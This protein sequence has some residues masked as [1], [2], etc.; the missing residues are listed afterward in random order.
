MQSLHETQA[1]FRDAIV[2][3]E[4]QLPASLI[5]PAPIAGRLAIYR[6]HFREALV[7]H[8]VGRF[9]T[10]EWLIGSR[11]MAEF[12]EPFVRSSPPTAPCLAEYGAGFVDAL[13]VSGRAE[14]PAYLEDVAVLDWALGDV[15]VAIDHAPLDVAALASYPAE[16]L[17]DLTLRL[18]PGLRY[19]RSAWPVDA[20]VGIRL[21][22][23]APDHLHF[24]PEAVALEIRGAR[25]QFRIGRL[26]ASAFEFRS[27]LAD[28]EPLGTAIAGALAADP[29][30]DVSAAIAAVFAEGL[31]VEVSPS[32]QE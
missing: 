25:G 21:S 6:R 27:L 7:R 18:Q 13:K 31:V 15:A 14:L 1:A 17:P 19:R 11:A 8:I 26:E 28:G 2:S 5:A 20:L 29:S 32:N 3:L 9:P 22:D 12:A 4:P 30:F 16:S 23:K 24:V 10:V